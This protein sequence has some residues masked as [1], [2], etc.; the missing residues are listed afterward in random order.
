MEKSAQ[1]RGNFQ[2][3]LERRTG[4]VSGTVHSG[5]ERYS[6][7]RPGSTVLTVLC[8]S[9]LRIPGRNNVQNKMAS[10]RGA[11]NGGLVRG[12]CA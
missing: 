8:E 10:Q 3:G 7:P 11:R 5:L 1:A 9:V 12:S 4:D 2:K 6:S